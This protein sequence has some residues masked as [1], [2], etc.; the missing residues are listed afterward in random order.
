[1][2][3]SSSL[4]V[5]VSGMNMAQ[6]GLEVASHNI[7]NV[8]TPGYSRQR[9]NLETGPTWHAGA[10]GQMG[11]GVTAQNITR[12]HD[13]FLTRSIIQKTTEY[14]AISAK[15]D[16]IDNL[17]SFFNESGGNGI[18]AAMNDFF[19]TWDSVADGTDQPASRKEMVAA[20]ETLAQQVATRRA[21]MD[22]V[23]QD[24][25]AR[26]D[27]AVDDI[28]TIL[29]SVS[30]LNQQIMTYEDK[31]RNQELNDMRDTRDALLTQLGELIST[32]QWEDPDNG[33]VNIALTCGPALLLNN[34]VYEM[35]T[36]TDDSGDVRVIANNRRTAP[37]WPEDVTGRLEGGMV[38]GWTQFRDTTLRDFYLQ[39]ESFADNLIFQ[40]NN[41]HAQGSGPDLYTQCEASN[42]VSGHPSQ[43][44]S[45][46]GR[47]N[48]IKV[49]ALV[50]HME[51]REP[52]D[53]MADPENIAVRFEKASEPTKEI[54]S[55]VRWNNGDDSQNWEITIVLPTDSNGNVTAT[56]EDV[57]R[58]INTERTPT[59]TGGSAKLPPQSTEWPFK[60][61]DFI[62]AQA[63]NGENWGGAVSFQGK[64]FPTGDK[65]FASLDRTLAN[66][67]AMGR[68][69]SHGSEYASLT[70][71]LKH[72]DN[73][74][75]F[76][77]V[78]KG[79]AGEKIALEYVDPA[80]ANQA[81]G[82]TVSKEIDGTTRVSISLATDSNGEVTTTAADIKELVNK[83][84]ETR[85]LLEAS[86]PEG[87]NGTGR[88]KAMDKAYLDRSGS[89]DLVTYGP[90][91]EADITRVVVDPTDTL[92]DVAGRIGTTFGEGV[93]GVRAEVLTDKNG[94]QS[95]RLIA[96]TETGYEYGFRHDTSG[97]L[98]VLGLNNVF[99]GDGSANVGVSQRLVDN[100]NL[101][102]TGRISSDGAKAKDG[103]NTNALDL[104][105]LKDQRFSFYGVS[106]ATL[107]TAFNTFYSGIG[108]ENRLITTK[109]DFTQGV[110]QD[111]TDRQDNL[112][113]VNLDEELADVLKYQYMYQ[114]SAKMVSTIDSMYE[115]LLAMR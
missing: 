69:L 91:G 59:P 32:E 6:S 68:H 24:L 78:E 39:Y 1:M 109:H 34:T 96:D 52:Y 27:G 74:L 89:F 92:A 77:A 7:S 23:R 71:A 66:S 42:L 20:A 90:D 54:T 2:G 21:D 18:N 112:A 98:A 12:Y 93:A 95:L 64:S 26:V 61:G 101:L 3:I 46:A 44:F 50:P 29:H 86:T 48:D 35:G 25:N 114:A 79:A 56:A 53:P 88:V 82:L 51:A 104:A 106:E 22:A 45:F 19:N 58:H 40:V 9:L 70:T 83:S 4:Y 37:P 103:D 13:E 115:T 47:D 75:T 43:T 49:T 17:E 94:Q 99:T 60:V 14:G 107:G 10:C 108:S 36:A 76:T 63:A 57:I 11:T 100:P 113:G 55:S 5:A 67:T 72:T 8:H 81:L 73:D 31:G 16:S 80:G 97:A 111:L 87:Q 65:E 38:G 102:G 62:S 41:Q 85:N 105:D 84:K 28:N 15:K 110:L 33:A 30:K